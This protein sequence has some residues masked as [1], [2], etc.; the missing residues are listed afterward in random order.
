VD[1]RME[2]PIVS[3]VSTACAVD[4]DVISAIRTILTA[5]EEH[6]ERLRY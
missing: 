5:R 1:L 4:R 6:R 2:I 3:C